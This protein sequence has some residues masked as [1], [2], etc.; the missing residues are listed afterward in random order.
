MFIMAIQM[1]ILGTARYVAL[2]I[3]LAL[4]WCMIFMAMIPLACAF[5]CWCLFD[6]ITDW[7][8]HRGFEPPN[9]LP[10]LPW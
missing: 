7:I 9:Y 1:C 2:P 5:G 3:L 4:I 8:T 10:N 6:R